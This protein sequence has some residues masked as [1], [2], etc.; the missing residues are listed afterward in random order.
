M[1]HRG[2][3]LAVILIGLQPLVAADVSNTQGFE[4]ELT[5]VLRA[6]ILWNDTPRVF[7]V[8]AAGSASMAINAMPEAVSYCSH[9][10]G[11]CARYS[12]L[13]FRNWLRLNSA[14]CEGQNSDLDALVAF[15]GKGSVKQSGDSA[16]PTVLGRGGL[17][18]SPAPGF[19]I[20]WTTKIALGSRAEIVK[21]Y[22]Q[23]H[24]SDIEGLKSWLRSP[25]TTH[26]G[27][28]AMTIACY[29]PF[30]PLVYYY[31]DR[32]AGAPVILAVFWDKDRQEW[33]IAA[34]FERSQAPEKFDEM[35]RTI[36]SVPCSTVTFQ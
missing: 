29:S 20:S 8:P 25:T 15:L 35:R 30:D 36:E 31:V 13:G 4:Q 11:T 17:A 3:M 18:G 21:E 33:V 5:A 26:T 9:D 34:S 14:P 24:P 23:M 22:Q 12:V 27:V 28:R 10:L 19:G 1:I 16:R 32:S 6:E 2:L 7:R